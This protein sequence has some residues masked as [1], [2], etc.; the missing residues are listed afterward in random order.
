MLEWLTEF[1][2]A[3]A[4]NYLDRLW[5]LKPRDD[6]WLRLHRMLCAKNLMILSRDNLSSEV[7]QTDHLAEA[8]TASPTPALQKPSAPGVIINWLRAL[9]RDESVRAATFAFVLTRS[10]ILFLFIL[11]AQIQIVDSEVGATAISLH[12]VQISRIINQR[13]AV[14][15]INWYREIAERGYERRPFTT[16]KQANWAFFPLFPILWYLASHVTGE[17]P[18]SGMALSAICFFFTLLLLHKTIL[19][20]GWNVPDADRT[21]FYLA[22]FPVSYF[23]SLPLTES[24][25]LFLTVGCFYAAKREAWLI[26]G[27]FGALASATRITGVLLLPA[28]ALIYWQTYRTLRPRLNFLPLLLIPTGL[29]A[30][31]FFLYRITGNAFAFKDIGVTW[32]RKPGFFLKPLF[33]YLTDPLLLAI[34]W[35]FRLM[36]FLAVTAVLICGLVLLKWRRWSLAFYTLASTFVALSSSLLQS[37]AR[38]AMVVFP[39]FI[40][41]AVAGRN[42][43]VDT[44]IRTTSLILLV[45][46]TI[47]FC[48]RL[49]IALS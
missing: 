22:A 19:E 31:M 3:F 29:L 34:P 46:I 43:R 27:I 10:M 9:F 2:S 30:F 20:F 15:D 5:K 16:E 8:T 25:F 41:L 12:K 1:I 21:V 33:E 44:A 40:V 18:F 13:V 32:G 45:L 35:D 7:R 4:S 24:L 38:Y 14:G 23:F 26:A 28:L 42:P 47:M 11:T 37:Q 49:D 17:Y 48:L 6:E 36:N 39:A